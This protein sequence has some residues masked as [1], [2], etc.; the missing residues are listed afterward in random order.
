MDY[1]DLYEP[2]LDDLPIEE[3]G[4]QDQMHR[5]VHECLNQW[6]TE[7][8]ATGG[9]CVGTFLDDLA[10]AGYRVTPIPDPGPIPWLGDGPDPAGF[11]P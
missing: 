5:T 6:I 3:L 10:L 8:V 7:A 4:E 9:H 2:H 1:L 11:R